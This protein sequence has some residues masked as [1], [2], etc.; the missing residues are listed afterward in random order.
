MKNIF[1]ITKK[2]LRSYFNH[3]TGYILMVVFLS[4]I[5]FFYF[6][7]IL[8]NSEATMRPLFDILPWILMFYVPA[9]TMNLVAKEKSDGTLEIIM[10]QPIKIWQLILGKAMGAFI[11]VAIT[12]LITLTIPLSLAH[13]GNFD[14]GL[15]FSQYLGSLFLISALVTIGL[16]ASSVTKN[17]IVAF[18]SSMA[19]NFFLIFIGFEIVTTSLP[20]PFNLILKKISILSHFYNIARGVLDLRD[21]FYF[22]CLIIIFL[23]LSYQTFLKI[24]GGQLKRY[25][26]I[27]NLIIVLIIAALIF[28]LSGDFFKAR[29]DLT[30]DKIFTLSTSTKHILANLNDPLTI[31][32]FVSKKLPVQIESQAQDV[33]DLLADYVASSN[34]KLELNVYYPDVDNS[35]KTL[36]Q[37]KGVPPVQF[38]IIAKDKFQAEQSYL[39]L[40]IEKK[41]LASSTI[42]KQSDK[43]NSHTA[44][45]A[46]I[47]FIQRTDNLEYQLTSRIWQLTR[48]QI[49]KIAWLEGHAEASLERDFPFIQKE[50][51]KEYKIENL[52]LVNS[53]V[54]KSGDK[55]YKDIPSDI[56]TLVV[57]GPRQAISAA[58]LGK[59]N[60]YLQHGGSALIL[61]NPI[62]VNLR[63]MTATS[64]ANNLNLML[65]EWGVKV[66][67]LLVYDLKSNENVTLRG[68]AVNYILPYPFWVRT[69]AN[70]DNNI[71]NNLRSVILP[72]PSPLEIIK[73][74]LAKN[75]QVIP[76]LLTSKYAGTIGR[77]DLDI[78]PQRNWP[79]DKLKSQLLAVALQNNSAEHPFRIVVVGNTQFVSGQ[80]LQSSPS[81]GAFLLNALEWLSQDQSLA[82]I[83]NK[84]LS[85]APLIF[86]S[87]SQ[88][89]AI[90]YANMIGVPILIILAGA[91]V[92][93][94]RRRLSHKKFVD[95]NL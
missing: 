56:A 35:A 81:N 36:A 59:I 53:Q 94:K 18:I 66:D 2:E 85:R 82:T 27:G 77:K 21:V 26:K 32:L 67:N 44:K 91:L 43:S 12:L 13:F 31:S 17:Q 71:L 40:V 75:T 34:G 84:N 30:Q 72:W 65:G 60:Y 95:F 78:S 37:Q 42:G 20:Y 38:N 29:L 68:R 22:I 8:I 76:L 86:D 93:W 49:K 64:T 41:S 63:F 10:T 46:T 83:R 4:L 19:V 70:Q 89:S 50:L 61:A 1:T 48:P 33:K 87:E 73:D 7:P 55:K 11:F 9:V 74:K 80:F 6:K 92:L 69:L 23:F 14:Y 16:W 3:P 24:K 57:A 62:D 39:G 45:V 25:R 28:N 52:N 90:K 5:Y 15:I 88:Q 51:V 58:E 54:D 79:Q 47:P